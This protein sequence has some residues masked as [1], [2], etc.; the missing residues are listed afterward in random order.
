MGD[1]GAGRRGVQTQRRV[2]AGRHEFDELYAAEL[3]RV[4]RLAFLRVRSH[5]VAEELAQEA[6]LRLYQHWDDVERP[7]G[8]VRTVLV[9]LALTWQRRH[10][11]EQRRLAVVGAGTPTSV[12]APEIDETWEAL[13]RLRPHLRAVLVLRFYEQMRHHEIAA[14]VGCP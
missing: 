14:A 5:A 13:G 3:L 6:F 1:V 4:T 12:A 9:R 10:Q 2:T 11:M 8:F 7:A